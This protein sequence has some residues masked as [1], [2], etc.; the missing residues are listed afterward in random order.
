[1]TTT[2]IPKTEPPIATTGAGIDLSGL[3]LAAILCS[4]VCHDLIGPVAAVINGLELLEIEDDPAMG[5]EAV[6]LI[7]KSAKSASAKLQ[8]CR[9][10]FGAS[11]APG[12]ELD[13]GEAE[14]AARSMIDTERTKLKWEGA[15]RKVAKNAV[16]AVLNLCLVAQSCVPRAGTVVVTLEGEG[17][18]AGFRVG[19]HGANPRM[20]PRVSDLL[21]NRAEGA[22][23]DAH[24]IH[25][26]YAGCLAR[27]VGLNLAI[28]TAPD[29]ITFA[30]DP[31]QAPIAAETQS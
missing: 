20:P 13:T 29:A 27:S 10:A 3:D 12:G 15:P 30:L 21:L 31:G 16:K 19:A 8:F 14:V 4:R 11:G 9:L 2:E 6:D 23:V 28:M 25:A 26:Y 18:A 7:G 5:K 1:M 22:P 17:R 24:V